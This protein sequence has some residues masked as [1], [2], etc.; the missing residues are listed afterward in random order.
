MSSSSAVS[1][2]LAQ[3]MLTTVALS[4]SVAC[5]A[6]YNSVPKARIATPLLAL[7]AAP[8]RSRRTSPL[9]N[10]SGSRP[11]SIA[12]PTPAPRGYR[13]ATGWSCSNAVV[14]RRRHSF[15]SGGQAMLIF[16]TQRR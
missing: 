16:G 4:R 15:S 10:G 14:S 5:S 12:A 1:S 13:T 11:G 8:T 3:R 9:P 7:S 2:G 6:G